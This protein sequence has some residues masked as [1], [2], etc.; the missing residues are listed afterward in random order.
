MLDLLKTAP[1]GGVELN[2]GSGAE[3]EA[4]IMKIPTPHLHFVSHPPLKRNTVFNHLG[5]GHLVSRRNR[6]R[7]IQHFL[8]TGRALLRSLGAAHR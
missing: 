8:I 1:V 6:F 3:L 2:P 7:E 4:G 5:G